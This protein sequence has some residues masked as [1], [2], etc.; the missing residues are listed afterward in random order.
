MHFFSSQFFGR[1]FVRTQNA[2]PF[3]CWNVISHVICFFLLQTHSLSNFGSCN[4]IRNEEEAIGGA[5][6]HLSAAVN[7]ALAKA[8]ASCSFFYDGSLPKWGRDECFKLTMCR[9]R[10]RRH[11]Y[12]LN[13]P[14]E[15]K[16]LLLCYSFP[17]FF[18]P[19]FLLR[20]FFDSC[21]PRHTSFV[22][23]V[24][25]LTSEELPRFSIKKDA[26]EE[27]RLLLRIVNVS[28]FGFGWRWWEAAAMEKL[29][30][31]KLTL[32]TCVYVL[33]L[34]F[35]REISPCFLYHRNQSKAASPCGFW[36]V[37][38]EQ[39]SCPMKKIKFHFIS[40]LYFLDLTR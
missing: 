10:R 38:V 7:F 2:L 21:S 30:W 15:N 20:F 16:A 28:V 9:D 18:I 4:N 25:K 19:L 29:N 22:L 34:F 11:F 31:K 33:K 3:L 32:I 39:K 24:C 17:S 23:M 26:F 5:G 1:T 8:V 13:K 6:R 40:N 36:W 37:F 35:F 27:V 14:C 12:Y